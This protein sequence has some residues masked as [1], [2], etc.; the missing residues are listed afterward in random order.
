[1]NKLINELKEI[2]MQNDEHLFSLLCCGVDI[3]DVL[4]DYPDYSNI[5]NF[6]KEKFY[7]EITAK[8]IKFLK[9][10]NAQSDNVS[11]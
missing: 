4:F 2:E 9:S 5:I 8:R 7:D 1:M 10:Y 11:Y 6:V 3:D